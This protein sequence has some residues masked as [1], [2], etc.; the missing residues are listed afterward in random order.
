MARSRVY[1]FGFNG[2]TISAVQDLFSIAAGANMAIELH[3]IV[4]GQITQTTVGGARLRLRFMPSTFTQGSGGT[5]PTPKPI[6]PDDAAT[7]V[8]AH[9]NDTT[10]ASTSGTSVDLPD[11]WNL[12]N[13]YLW[14]PPI[15]DRPIVK[16]SAGFVLS[17]DTALSSLVCSG[18]LTFAELF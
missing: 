6:N 13:G 5:A 12:L 3:S 10:Q 11:V 2:V 7:S 17:L 15:D 16:P 1:I 9:V 8:T 18:N 14:L 4:L